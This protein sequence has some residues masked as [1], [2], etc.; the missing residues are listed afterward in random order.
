MFR[1]V[2][3]VNNRVLDFQHSDLVGPQSQLQTTRFP[4]LDLLFHR[5]ALDRKSDAGIRKCFVFFR[6]IPH[7]LRELVQSARK[8]AT[9]C[10]HKR[11]MAECK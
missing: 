9:A 1:G 7:R 2:C 8:R 6:I 4:S 5:K 11:V 10:P 3:G